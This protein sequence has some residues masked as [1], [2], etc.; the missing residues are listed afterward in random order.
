MQ[1]RCRVEAENLKRQP[2]ENMKSYIHRIKTLGDKLWPTP[3]DADADA[4][5]ACENQRVGKYKDF[6]IRG[7]KHPRLKE[8]AHQALIEDPIKT[9]DAL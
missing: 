3:S 4:Q 7:L 2:D 9:W 6:F 8:K 1:Y 5:T